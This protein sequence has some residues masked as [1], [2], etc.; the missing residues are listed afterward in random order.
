MPSKPSGPSYAIAAKLANPDKQVFVL[1]GDGSFG[2]NGMEYEAAAR[3]KIPFV[4]VI[5]NDA[6]WMQIRRGQVELYGPTRA[7]ATE[8][9]LTRYERVVEALSHATER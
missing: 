1:F 2:L 5:G 3:Q 7:P 4:G 8:L 6:A 9:G